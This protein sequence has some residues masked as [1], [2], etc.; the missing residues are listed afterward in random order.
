MLEVFFPNLK[1]VLSSPPFFFKFFQVFGERSLT[2]LFLLV[3]LNFSCNCNCKMCFQRNDDYYMSRNRFLSKNDFLLLLKSALKSFRLKPLIHFFGGEPLLNPNFNDFLGL[4]RKEKFTGSLT[5]NG[6]LLKEVASEIVKSKSIRQVNVSL[7]GPPRVHDE[8][9]RLENC[10]NKAIEG[11]RE[12]DCYKNRFST[13]YPLLNVN[14]AINEGNFDNIEEFVSIFINEPINSLSFGHLVFSCQG[15]KR[16]VNMDVEKL[17]KQ[18]RKIRQK[19]LPYPVYF[20]PPIKEEDIEKY[21]FDFDYPFG[22]NCFIPWLGLGILPNLEVTPGGS[23]FACNQILGDLKKESL[24]K[25]W[26][27]ARLR[28]FRKRIKENGVPQACARCCHRQF[29]D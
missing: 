2:P 12:I 3:H 21:Y 4:L 20:L 19:K 9:R 11:I 6:F 26:D 18:L 29:Y 10:F 13:K 23:M 24:G 7:D 8:I 5:T 28:A 14:F 22:K 25:I 17:I 16:P 15:A 27:S 1:A